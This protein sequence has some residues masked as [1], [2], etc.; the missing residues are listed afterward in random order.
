M[1]EIDS[2][3]MNSSCMFIFVENKNQDVFSNS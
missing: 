1:K 2:G 3:F